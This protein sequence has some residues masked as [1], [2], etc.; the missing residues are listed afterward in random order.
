MHCFCNRSGNGG[1][2]CSGRSYQTKD[3]T[4]SLMCQFA[5]GKELHH[6]LLHIFQTVMTFLKYFPCF[7]QIIR[8]CGFLLPRKCQHGLN[9]TTQYCI[10]GYI[11]VGILKSLDFFAD[12]L[13]YLIAGLKF[14]EFLLKLLC[15]I[16]S[17]ILTQ[18]LTY[19]FQLL[20]ENIFSLILI[21]SGLHFFLEISANL[22]DLNLISKD[23]TQNFITFLQCKCLQDFLLILI[24]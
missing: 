20:S 9:I 1:F 14:L 19:Q 21:N 22:H 2:T 10:L 3:R 12:L 13:F 5:D 8:I 16:R 15:V 24:R 17:I 6:T 18:F 4:F 7:F 23:C 11:A